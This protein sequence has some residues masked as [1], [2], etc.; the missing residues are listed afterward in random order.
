MRHIRLAYKYLQ[1]YFTAKH[2]KGFGVHSPFVYHFTKF[3]IYEKNPFYIFSDIEYLR[4]SLLKDRRKITVTDFG[5]GKS[6]ERTIKSIA[7]SSLKEAE[8]GRLFL[9]II[10][11][12][13]CRNVLELG[14]SLG[15]TTAYLASGAKNIACT[16][17]EGCPETAKVAIAGFEKLKLDNI[18]LVLGNLDEVLLP[19]LEKNSGLDFVFIDANHRYEA[20]MRYFE[21]LLPNLNDNSMLIVDDLYWSAGMEDAWNAIKQHPKVMVTIDL[22][23]LGIV[24][25]NPHLNKKH[26]KMRL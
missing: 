7:R 24:F 2:Y 18:N 23:Q 8:Y 3:V 15:I 12:C 17:I 14:T 22:F 16:T 4:Q 1:H 19:Q 10:N 20:L 25:F 21:Q 9:R 6:R 11:Y 26:Y 5:T 13:G